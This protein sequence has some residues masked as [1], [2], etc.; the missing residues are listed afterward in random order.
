MTAQSIRFPT[1]ATTLW[2]SDALVR[3]LVLAVVGTG[4]LTLSAKLKIPFYPVPMTMQTLV[5][6]G[7]GMVYGWKLG[8]ATVG[9][10]LA[11]GALGMPVFAGTPEKGIGLAYMMGP[12]G[13]YLLGFILAA[14]VTGYLAEKGWDRRATTTFLAMLIGNIV[15]YVPGLIWLGSVVGWDKP[16]FAWGITPFL[17]GDLVKILVAMIVLPGAWN[18][19][20]KYRQ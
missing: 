7:L 20:R 2:G 4:L 13:G 11:A 9:V 5:V 15:V 1:L 10:Y 19:V 14:A 16:V 17:F 3:N 8:F 6:L 18:L 12:T